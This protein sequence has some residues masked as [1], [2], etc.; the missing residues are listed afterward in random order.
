[1]ASIVDKLLDAMEDPAET[2]SRQ[3]MRSMIFTDPAQ[4]ILAERIQVLLLMTPRKPM[5][6]SMIMIG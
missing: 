3:E 4:T 5:Y 1:M 6:N 2:V